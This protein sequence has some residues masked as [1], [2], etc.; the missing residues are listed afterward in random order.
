MT[1]RHASSKVLYLIGLF[2][3]FLTMSPSAHKVR[4]QPGFWNSAHSGG[5]KAFPGQTTAF[6]GNPGSLNLKQS[7]H[8]E[9]TT[10]ELGAAG[11]FSGAWVVPAGQYSSL[12]IAWNTH[13]I[14]TFDRH[15]LRAGLGIR[16]TEN[17]SLGMI[18]I[19]QFY[20]DSLFMDF[21]LG[22]QYSLTDYLRGGLEVKQLTER[23]QPRPD[24]LN[25]KSY[26]AGL[27][28]YPFYRTNK[29][30]FM[31]HVDWESRF[32][33]LD[34]DRYTIGASY[35]LGPRENLRISSAIS[36]IDLDT[37][38]P[39]TSSVGI[40]VQ[41]IFFSSLLS[42]HY[43]VNQL[44]VSGATA[45]PMRHQ[46]GLGLQLY[47]SQ[48]LTPP[49]AQINASRSL[50]DFSVDNPALHRIYFLLSAQDD[51]NQFESWYLVISSQNKAMQ[52]QEVVKSFKGQGH[53]P[54]QI[55]WEGRDTS[56]ERLSKGYYSYRLIV[57][58]QER[59]HN[60]TSWQFLEIK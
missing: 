38:Q 44:P 33:T 31:L 42:F 15:E 41:E 37:L 2:L 26:G 45:E 20:Q 5:V 60:A 55:V 51:S 17:L 59:N 28:F 9:V 18:G 22:A 8:V 7:Q 14:E 36:R 49:S 30:N 24:S 11:G 54:K 6:W 50:L 12:G 10:Y 23:L 48:D 29:K 58:D 53:P 27:I 32:I 16:P 13:P 47:P 43:T 57:V 35:A 39:I 56:G 19:G 40:R 21:S 25:F 4:P 3:F 46:I 52:P 1:P 34:E